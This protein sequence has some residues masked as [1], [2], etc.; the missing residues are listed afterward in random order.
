MAIN[1]PSLSFSQRPFPVDTART[2][3]AIGYRNTELIADQVLPYETVPAEKFS[4]LK[5][6]FADGFTIP[7]TKVGRKSDPNQ[8]S[9]SAEN[10]TAQVEAYGLEDF[11]P[12][13]DI[14]N[15]PAPYSPVDRSVMGIIDLITLDREVRVAN[16]VM[17]PGNYTTNKK[18]MTNNE[19][20][21]TTNT[22]LDPYEVIAE[23]IN[24]MLIKPN[25]SV[26]GAKL[27]NYLRKSESLTEAYFG[28]ASSGKVLKKQEF[29][30]LFE[31]NE[32]LV[33]RSFVNTAKKGQ[34]VS[35]ANA[36]TTN[37]LLMNQNTAS[38]NSGTFGFTARYGNRIAA[39][40]QV[41][42]RGLT[43]GVEIWAGEFVKELIC[44][45][46]HGYLISNCIAP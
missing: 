34:A 19:R 22:G 36:W 24:A 1:T 17:T 31:L 4:Y 13:S 42:K 26:M 43:G 9:F 15:A 45:E 29:C 6:K 10:L 14:D 33:G 37:L 16:L 12:Q 11:V 41:S 2:A 18:A 20:F 35:L 5:H 30:E 28:N 3:I 8:V 23:A 40:E 32:L 46:P 21:G 38:T 7:D 27:W 44:S 39:T 25:K